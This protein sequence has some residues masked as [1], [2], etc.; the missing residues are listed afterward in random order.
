[1]DT[2]LDY[3]DAQGIQWIMSA[4]GHRCGGGVRLGEKI[5]LCPNCRLLLQVTGKVAILYPE[6][7]PETEKEG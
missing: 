5:A 6:R 1:M 7:C 2:S 3:V 4:S